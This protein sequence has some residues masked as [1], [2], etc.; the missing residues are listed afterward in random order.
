VS[1]EGVTWFLLLSGVRVVLDHNTDATD[2]TILAGLTHIWP[3]VWVLAWLIGSLAA[4][5]FGGSLLV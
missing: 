5:A 3:S 4:L 2:A 1:G